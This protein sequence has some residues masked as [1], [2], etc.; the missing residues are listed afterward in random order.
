MLWGCFSSGT[1]K[2][3]R[4][5]GKMQVAKHRAK[6]FDSPKHFAKATLEWFQSTNLNVLE[7]YSQSQDSDH[8]NLYSSNA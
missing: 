4:V 2:L 1:G 5:T 6:P 7:W 8:C 3:V